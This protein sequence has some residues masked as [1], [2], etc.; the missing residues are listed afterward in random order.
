MISDIPPLS[1]SS[2]FVFHSLLL[3]APF[4]IGLERFLYQDSTMSYTT[5]EAGLGLSSSIIF[6][7][8][9]YK[10]DY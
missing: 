5:L 1:Q 8:I 2:Q 9:F 6:L 3:V 7:S 10:S 4:L